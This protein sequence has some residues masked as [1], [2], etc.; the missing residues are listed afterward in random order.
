MLKQERLWLTNQQGMCAGG[1]GVEN[2][3][4]DE[5]LKKNLINQMQWRSLCLIYATRYL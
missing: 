5:E 4:V 3:K 1:Y 2:E